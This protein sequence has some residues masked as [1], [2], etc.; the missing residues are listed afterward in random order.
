M[1]PLVLFPAY[2]RVYKTEAELRQGFIDGNDFRAEV[3]GPYLSIRD[4]ARNE[5]ALDGYNRAILVQPKKRGEKPLVVEFARKDMVWPKQ[6][7]ENDGEPDGS[8]VNQDP[9]LK[10]FDMAEMIKRSLEYR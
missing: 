10:P 1:D 7:P 2:G 4:W 9:D 8:Y 5:S 3:G 6:F